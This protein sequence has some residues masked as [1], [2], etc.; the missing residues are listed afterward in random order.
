MTRTC[1]CE[2][3]AHASPI[4]MGSVSYRATLQVQRITL[5]N[6]YKL[7]TSDKTDFRVLEPSV[8]V[9]STEFGCEMGFKTDGASSA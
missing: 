6:Y 3:L 7:K 5:C 1:M 4:E 2:K 8:L 9:L